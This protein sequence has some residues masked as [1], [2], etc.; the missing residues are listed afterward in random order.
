MQPPRVRA[1]AP[2][3]DALRRNRDGDALRPARL[4]RDRR[5]ADE[6]P[7]RLAEPGG[8]RRIGLRDVR[9]RAHRCS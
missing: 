4:Q 3:R 2:G 7:R 5:P 6:P 1:R 9:A 8:Q